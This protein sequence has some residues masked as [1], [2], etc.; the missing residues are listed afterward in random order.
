MK[1]L[2]YIVTI[3]LFPLWVQAQD[4]TQVNTGEEIPFIAS[5]MPEFPG[6]MKAL[7]QYLADSVRYPE[8]A[9]KEN[10]QGRVICLFNVQRDGTL[11]DIEVVRSSGHSILDEEA[12]RVFSTMPKWNPATIHKTG[13]LKDTI[14]MKYSCPITF[15]LPDTC[16]I[17][18]D[19]ISHVDQC[20]TD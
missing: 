8:Q 10:I 1:R 15:R 17:M 9:I 6:G 7:F 4:T 12:I 3:C 5:P 14:T 11:T 18:T 2:I 19:T 16:R 13:G 20:P